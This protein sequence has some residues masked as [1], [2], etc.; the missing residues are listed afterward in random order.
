MT[1]LMTHNGELY[2]PSGYNS[3]IYSYKD[4]ARQALTISCEV[5]TRTP[6][7]MVDYTNLVFNND[8]YSCFFSLRDL[9]QVFLPLL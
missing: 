7:T 6:A 9:A 3:T 5:N 1:E 4:K 2:I 8:T